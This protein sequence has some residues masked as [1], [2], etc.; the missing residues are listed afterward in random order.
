MNIESFV[1]GVIVG[2][3]V[4]AIIVTWAYIAVQRRRVVSWSC[5]CGHVNGLNLATC[6]QCGRKPGATS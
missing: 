5:G 6:A 1:V 3:A 4:G 2:M